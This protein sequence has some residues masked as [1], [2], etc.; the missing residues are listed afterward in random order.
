MRKDHANY[1]VFVQF[2]SILFFCV[3]PRTL[4]CERVSYFHR[5]VGTVV[6]TYHQKIKWQIHVVILV[7]V[8]KTV[9][10]LFFV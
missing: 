3:F 8:T 10:V 2:G 4:R 9:H 5:L 6:T 7:I 1:Y